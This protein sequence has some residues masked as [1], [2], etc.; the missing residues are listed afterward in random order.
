MRASLLL[1]AAILASCAAPGPL[2]P[3]AASSL[4]I[5]AR[6]DATPAPVP[7]VAD[8]LLGLFNDSRMRR[9][10]NQALSNNP[11]LKGSLAR[12]EEAG[13]NTRKTASELYPALDGNASAGR[14]RLPSVGES[15]DFRLSLDAR[16]ELDVWGRIR[17]G[18]TASTA[19]QAAAAAD[20][21]SARQSLAAQSMQSW[22]DL[23]AAEKRLALGNRRVTSFEDTN[24]LVARRFE[25]GTASLA[26]LE[27][28]RTDLENARADIEQLKDNRDRAARTLNLLTGAY[29]DA[30]ISASS[31]PSLNRSVPSGVP[32]DLL[33]KR[34]DVDAAYQRL[35]AAD[36]RVKVA[37]ADLFPSFPLTGS[38][39][40]S[41]S[42]LSNL[43]NSSFDTWSVV[44]GLSAPIFDAG[45][46]QAEL[47]AAGKRAEQAL[48]AWQSTVLSAF[49]EVEDA[50]GSERLLLQQEK[51]RL[52]ALDAARSAETRTRRDYEAGISDLLS[53]FEAQRRVFSTED[54]TINLHAAR[55]QNRVALALALGKGV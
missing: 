14:S 46:R 32:S 45:L 30:G 16:W 33:L 27:L 39:G 43:A 9:A 15:S 44:A 13:F 26:D 12:M 31:W 54:D 48:A 35:R 23:V 19:D 42:L 29:P 2:A 41:S 38:V 20:Y 7:Q 25:L 52:Q 11:D 28:T 53:L 49:K 36:S 22:F 40:N 34:P 4:E 3:G 1:C 50:L 10:V 51:S 24:R 21:A 8:S 17:A 6:F 5:P 37:H 18:V 47:G 55:L